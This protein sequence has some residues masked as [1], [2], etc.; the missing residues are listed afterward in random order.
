MSETFKPILEAYYFKPNSPY[1]L[2]QINVP[3]LAKGATEYLYEGGSTKKSVFA[4]RGCYYRISSNKVLSD[5]IA[6]KEVFS[7]LSAT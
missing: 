6:L 1:R 4:K 3:C 2:F 7:L 5:F